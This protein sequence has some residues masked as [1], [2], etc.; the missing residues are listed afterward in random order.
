[1]HVKHVHVCAC[2]FYDTER[3]RADLV[4]MENANVC[5]SVKEGREKKADR[6]YFLQFVLRKKLLS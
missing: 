4:R 2:V 3:N 1:M 6:Y 5:V